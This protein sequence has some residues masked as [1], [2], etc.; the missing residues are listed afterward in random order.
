MN[1]IYEINAF[2]QYNSKLVNFNKFNVIFGIF[3]FIL[4]SINYNVF[5]PWT[6][7]LIM[8]ISSTKETKPKE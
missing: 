5:R 1:K 8:Q 6:L 2:K 3:N 7:T 4:N